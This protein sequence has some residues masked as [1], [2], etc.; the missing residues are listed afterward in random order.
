MPQSVLANLTAEWVPPGY[1]PLLFAGLFL[2][3]IGTVVL[4]CFGV[5]AYRQRRSR[6]YL[7]VTLAL[8]A[9]V[10]RTLVGWGTVVGTVPMVV[11]HVLA[12]GLDFTIAVLILYT[13]YQSRPS[14]PSTIHGKDRYAQ[15][16]A[17]ASDSVNKEQ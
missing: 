16:E 9:L 17:S 4:F 15:Q 7:L 13:A 12:H 10:L 11:H 8:G 6:E 14:P 1:A 3:G 5:A 2:A